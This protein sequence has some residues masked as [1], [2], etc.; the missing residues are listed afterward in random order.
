MALTGELQTRDFRVAQPG[1]WEA[2]GKRSLSAIQ[3]KKQTTFPTTKLTS[4]QGPSKADLFQPRL[5]ALFTRHKLTQASRHSIP[6]GTHMLLPKA[7][8][9]RLLMTSN[10]CASGKR[11]S[12]EKA[13]KI[14]RHILESLQPHL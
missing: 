12:K 9:V 6:D 10:F 14:K 5:T 3:S 1:C 2:S 4:T 8:L 11:I 7:S 13:P